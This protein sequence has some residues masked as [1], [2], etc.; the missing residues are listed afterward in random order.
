MK[1]DGMDTPK[2]IYLFVNPRRRDGGGHEAVISL[3]EKKLFFIY[4]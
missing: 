3:L 1:N 4:I 2:G